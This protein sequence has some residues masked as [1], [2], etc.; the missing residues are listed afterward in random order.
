[1]NTPA[2]RGERLRAALAGAFAPDALDVVDESH[3]HAGHAGAASGKGHFRVR[4]VSNAF[5]GLPAIKRHRL[6]YGACAEL[7]ATDIHALSIDARA[8]D[9]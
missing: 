5:A 8:P 6:V 7:L 4:I 1:M 9:E 2:D 3:L